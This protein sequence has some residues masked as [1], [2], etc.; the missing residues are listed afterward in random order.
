MPVRRDAPPLD[1]GL[2][3]AALAGSPV[4]PPPELPPEVVQR[5]I[6]LAERAAVIRARSAG[7]AI[8][9]QDLLAGVRDR[10]V[11]AVTFLAMLELMKRREIVVEQAEPW[12]PIAPGVT[13]PRSERPQATPAPLDERLASFEMTGTNG[14]EPFGPAEER[15]VAR[16]LPGAHRLTE[17]E[18]EALLF[19]AERPLT[20]REIARSPVSTRDAWTRAGRPRGDAR[21]ARHPPRVSGRTGGAGHRTRGRGA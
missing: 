14:R 10:V 2:L 16:R 15:T 17:A 3:V 8:V 9:L 21:G 19:V 5:T 20:R 18:L 12:G 4:A 11:V 6:T 1:P 7:R 13:T